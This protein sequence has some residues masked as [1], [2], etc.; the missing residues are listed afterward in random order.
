MAYDVLTCREE[1]TVLSQ[2][3]MLATD[4]QID[5]DREQGESTVRVVALYE[6]PALKP[7]AMFMSGLQIGRAQ[8]STIH[9]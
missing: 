2:S 1:T 7:A 4:R 6:K 5:G 3:L 9:G 8:S